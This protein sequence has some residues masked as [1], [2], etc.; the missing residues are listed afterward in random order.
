MKLSA[1]EA[2]SLVIV[3]RGCMFYDADHGEYLADQLTG[4]VIERHHDV[5]DPWWIGDTNLVVAAF[6]RF[7]ATL[8]TR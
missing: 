8:A 5:N 1:I 7:L 3:R 4:A 2:P 6:D